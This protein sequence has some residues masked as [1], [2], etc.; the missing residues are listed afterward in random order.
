MLIIQG[1]VFA[2]LSIFQGYLALG[3]I[4]GIAGIGVVTVRS[5]SERSSQ[6]GMLRALGY[7]RGMTRAS[8]LIEVSWVALLGMGNGIAVAIGFHYAIY[9]RFWAEQGVEFSIPLSVISWLLIGGWALVILAS[10]VPIRRAMDISPS[11]ALRATN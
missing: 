3:L 9:Q 1:L 4:V 10:I 8:L 5:V 2:I 7:T 11:E 6:I